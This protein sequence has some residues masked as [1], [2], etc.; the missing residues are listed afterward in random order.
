MRSARQLRDAAS[1][2]QTKAQS[3]RN[4]AQKHRDKAMR[5]SPTE[6]PRLAMTE[7]DLAQRAEE[8]ALALEREKQAKQM[9]LQGEIERLEADERALR[10]E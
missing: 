7:N 9:Q 3:Q 8:K 2:L 5:Y 1:K 4:D 10:G 6:D